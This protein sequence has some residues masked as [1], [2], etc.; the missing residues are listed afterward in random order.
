MPILYFC[1]PE[2]PD[3][4]PGTELQAGMMLQLENGQ[5]VLLLTR[6][7]QGV[8]CRC[9]IRQQSRQKPRI[10]ALQARE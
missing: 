7:G 5:V 4:P 9:K 2:M 8:G 3:P 10:K 1:R 6:A